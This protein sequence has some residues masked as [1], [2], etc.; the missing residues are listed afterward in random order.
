M[1]LST[2]YRQ[3]FFKLNF[4]KQNKFLKI[5]IL[6]FK[7]FNTQSDKPKKNSSKENIDIEFFFAFPLK[8]NLKISQKL[9]FKPKEL[10]DN[11]CVCKFVLDKF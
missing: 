4:F 6:E 10:L 11:F 2:I 1:V 3:F 7:N 5:R 8:K 9:L